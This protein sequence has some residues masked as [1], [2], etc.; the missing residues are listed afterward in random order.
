MPWFYSLG[1]CQRRAKNTFI[2][3]AFAWYDRVPAVRSAGLENRQP[4]TGLVSSNLTLSAK[5]KREFDKIAEAILDARSAP[6]E[7]VTVGRTGC[8]AGAVEV[9]V[10]RLFPAAASCDG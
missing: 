9:S 2:A 10:T 1:T 3:S 8:E 6:A 7:R 5:S 4:F